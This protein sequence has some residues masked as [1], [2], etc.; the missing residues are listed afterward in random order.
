MLLELEGSTIGGH[1]LLQYCTGFR[2]T[3]IIIHKEYCCKKA[4]LEGKRERGEKKEKR[5]DKEESKRARREKRALLE[6]TVAEKV[7]AN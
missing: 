5:R 7:S 1:L 4:L 6:Y 3:A 2:A